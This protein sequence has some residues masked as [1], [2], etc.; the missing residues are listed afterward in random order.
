MSKAIV[1]VPTTETL[2]YADLLGDKYLK[3]IEAAVGKSAHGITPEQID[4]LL[5]EEGQQNLLRQRNVGQQSLR[6]I[7]TWL[8]FHPN[9]NTE[10]TK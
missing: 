4:R 7:R 5:S 3:A 2:R 8:A 1:K 9:R 10:D 6:H